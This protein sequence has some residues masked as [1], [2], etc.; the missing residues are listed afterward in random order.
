MQAKTQDAFI[1]ICTIHSSPTVPSIWTTPRQRIPKTLLDTVG[2][3]LDDPLYSDVEFVIAKR[4]HDRL[5]I[6][7]SI[8]A[9]KKMLC[10]ADYFQTSIFIPENIISII[11]R[12]KKLQCSPLVLLKT[13][14]EQQTLKPLRKPRLLI[15]IVPLLSHLLWR[16]S[17][18]RMT[19]T[20]KRLC[21]QAPPKHLLTRSM[22]PRNLLFPSTRTPRFS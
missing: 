7:R 4:Q 11:L 9:C 12:L 5:A 10:R 16:N 20:K 3:L 1:V 14:R 2:G 21:L 18:I 15:S 13:Q 22:L 6:T 19:R 8:Y 17:K